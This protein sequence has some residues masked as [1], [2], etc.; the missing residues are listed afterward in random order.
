MGLWR[1][2]FHPAVLLRWT[3]LAAFVF[4]LPTVAGVF[5]VFDQFGLANACFML[6]ASFV[7]AKIAQLAITSS[8]PVW[9]RL[10]FTFLL[11]GVVGI[12]IVE[13]VRGVNAYAAKKLHPHPATEIQTQTLGGGSAALASPQ[14]V[15]QTQHPARYPTAAEIASEVARHIPTETVG[16][17]GADRA[18]EANDNLRKRAASLSDD[19]YRCLCKWGWKDQFMPFDCSGILVIYP[20]PTPESKEQHQWILRISQ[21]FELRFFDRLVKVRDDFAAHQI[22]DDHLD[23]FIEGV[24]SNRDTNKTLLAIGQGQQRRFWTALPQELEQVARMLREM[25]AQ[26]H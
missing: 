19:I 2:H 11:F 18:H 15:T 13:T 9:H 5:L 26:L 20:Y 14:A 1:E 21:Y 3:V 25:N 10:V 6:T 24:T 22:R 17:V 23:Q 7:L 12:G 8:D 4:G 16:A